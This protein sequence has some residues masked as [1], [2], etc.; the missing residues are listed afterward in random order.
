LFGEQIVEFICLHRGCRLGKIL[1]MANSTPIRI[2]RIGKGRGSF[3]LKLPREW[4]RANNL[5]PGDL[6]MPDLD[7]FKIIRH[8]DLPALSQ[9]PEVVPAE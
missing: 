7:T 8:E 6:I 9:E 2:T 5:K 4:V 1:G 3:Y